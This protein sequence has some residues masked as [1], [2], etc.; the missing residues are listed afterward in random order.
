MNREHA[1]AV[2][3]IEAQIGEYWKCEPLVSEG[4]PEMLRTD[5]CRAAA[6]IPT[7]TG[8]LSRLLSATRW[9]ESEIVELKANI[10]SVSQWGAMDARTRREVLETIVHNLDVPF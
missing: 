5:A 8:A 1:E 10:E 7:R 3:V 6:A 2:A 9:C 4:P